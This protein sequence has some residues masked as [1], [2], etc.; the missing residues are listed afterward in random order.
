MIQFFFCYCN[1]IVIHGSFN[2]ELPHSYK[3]T[4]DFDSSLRKR[5][6]ID[7]F[8]VDE[9]SKRGIYDKFI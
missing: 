7:E 3:F 1:L 6:D 2:E 8:I 4:F 5:I 9:I